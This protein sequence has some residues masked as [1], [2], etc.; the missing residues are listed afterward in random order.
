MSRLLH[1]SG[2]E[3]PDLSVEHPTKRIWRELA[4]GFDE[5]HILAR[6]TDNRFHR[7]Q[8]GNMVLHLVPKLGR[9]WSFFATSVAMLWIVPRARIDVLLAQCPLFG[10]FTAAILSRLN[11]MP[12][13][14]EIHGMH[15]FN[16]LDGTGARD[17][18]LSAVMRYSFRHATKVRSLSD[19]MTD[20]LHS[21]QVEA[22]V[23]VIP[24][25]VDLSL[26]GPPKPDSLLSSP[27]YLIGVGTF[28]PRKSFDRA[29]EVVRRLRSGRDLHLNLIGGGPLQAEFEVVA[30]ECEY[31]HVYGRLSQSEIVSLLRSSDIYVQPSLDEG[32]PRAVLE[33]MAMRLPV[34]VSDVGGIAGVVV[35]RV[36]GMLIGPGNT[37]ELAEAV[38]SLIADDGLRERIASQAY[39]DV[40]EKYEWENVFDLYRAHLLEMVSGDQG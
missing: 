15:Y 13:M 32:V 3:F 17:R 18:L 31:I 26:F 5:Y 39:A 27:I 20:M 2:N 7:Y 40:C 9:S 16:I 34:V 4:K 28:V 10:G 33:A 1:I 8:E 12:L 35:D 29:I 38:E 36:N 14:V 37:D 21:R 25:R 6:S 22:N 11:K 23:V 24:N 30:Q 19:K